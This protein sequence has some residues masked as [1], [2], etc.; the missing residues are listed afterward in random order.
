MTRNMAEIKPFR[1]FRYNQEK[2]NIT[3]VVAPP[4]DVIS[5]RMQKSLCEKDPHNIVRIILGKEEESDTAT[6]NKYARAGKLLNMWFK[7]RLLVKDKKPSIYIYTQQYLHRGKKRTRIGFIALMKIENPSES[8]ILP[9]EYTLEG[10]KRDRLSLIINAQANLSPIFSLF[11]EK[12]NRINKILKNFIKSRNPTF[13]VDT[14]GVIHKLWKMD[15]K[16]ALSRIRRYMRD[17]KIFIA[18]GHHRYEVALSYRNMLRGKKAPNKNADY[19]MMYFS[20]LSE[21]GRITVLSTHR[22]VK[23]I[24]DFNKSKIHLKLEKYFHIMPARSAEEIIK[25]IEKTVGKRHVIGM[26]AGQNKFYLLT[27]KK[28]YPPGKLVASEKSNSL[29]KL[30]VTILHD[31]I[32]NK[33]LDVKNPENNIKYVRDKEAAL[34]LIDKGA[35]EL[36]FFLRPT[37]LSDMKRVAEK[38]EMMP[39]KSTYFYPKLLTGL[40]INK[41]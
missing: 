11:Q 12:E 14:D 17:K 16:G 30:D 8:R 36:A 25:N 5:S 38:G 2:V 20:N 22:V 37:A 34:S 6:N 29:K 1:G 41:L 10:P 35:Y 3:K 9:H 26:Y 40:V 28:D 19:V 21:K 31:V 15:A 24:K 32:I 13:T 23:N 27:L 33:I 39:Q 7:E 18:D 4:Y